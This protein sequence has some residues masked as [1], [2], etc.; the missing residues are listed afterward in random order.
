M[1][2]KNSSIANRKSKRE[3]IYSQNDVDA[4]LK[5]KEIRNQSQLDVLKET[6]QELLLLKKKNET[7]KEKLAAYE[8][9]DDGYCKRR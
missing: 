5:E 9:P 3:K 6:Y 8:N 7:L 2:G 4:I 1:E